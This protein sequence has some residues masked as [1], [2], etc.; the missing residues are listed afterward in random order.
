MIPSKIFLTGWHRWSFLEH[1]L[2]ELYRA[3]CQTSG[4]WT[5]SPSDSA[6]NTRHSCRCLS[7]SNSHNPAKFA[8]RRSLFRLRSARTGIENPRY[9]LF[10]FSVQCSLITFFPQLLKGYGN[11]L[12]KWTPFLY[13]HARTV[14]RSNMQLC[15]VLPL[16]GTTLRFQFSCQW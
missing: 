14:V 15:P 6:P 13:I 8:F 7:N 16:C 1:G 12:I 4:Q 3:G 11:I 2:S 9:I 5:V 10:S